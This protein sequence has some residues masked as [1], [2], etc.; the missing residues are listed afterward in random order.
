MDDQLN[1]G[2]EKDARGIGQLNP[3][4]AN[5]LI[6]K[7]I[8]ANREIGVPREEESAP[9]VGVPREEESAPGLAKA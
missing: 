6:G 5:L 4:N 7:S 2:E 1:P 9:G 3:G 8:K